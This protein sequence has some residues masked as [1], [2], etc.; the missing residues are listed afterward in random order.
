[1]NA[2]PPLVLRSGKLRTVD[3][4]NNNQTS[5]LGR[6]EDDHYDPPGLGAWIHRNPWLL[7][8]L[9]MVIIFTFCAYLAA[10]NLSF[11]LVGDPTVITAEQINRGELPA[12]IEQ[13]DYVEVR[14]TPSVGSEL[15]VLGTPESE[16]GVVSRYT[17]ANYFYFRLQNTGDNLLIQKAQA[18]P[19]F[20]NP[21]N[22][23]RGKLAT[24]G[25]VIFHDTTQQGLKQAGL[26]TR[27]TIPVIES[28]DTPQYYRQL[29]PAYLIIISLWL[30]SVIYL[31]WR[32]NKPFLD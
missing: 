27:E 30:L 4:R 20:E 21:P 12:G 15:R 17:S 8:R 22:V 29:F 13:G 26:P 31:L 3:T 24:V 25:T 9:G 11:G 5:T 2:A 14:G 6:Y 19:D 16:V 7:V 10:A 18:P 23:F 28:S 1:M 32:K